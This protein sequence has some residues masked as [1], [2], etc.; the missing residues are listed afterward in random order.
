MTT[1]MGRTDVAER[2]RH[3]PSRRGEE[4]RGRRRIRAL[5][6]LLGLAAIVAAGLGFVWMLPARASLVE[7][8]QALLA[9]RDRLADGDAGAARRE[10]A[11]AEAAFDEAG[12]RLDGPLVRLAAL[13]PI[14]GR[15]PDAVI[16]IAD[17]GELVARAAEGV[18]GA[19]EQLPG[20]VAALAPRNGTI[21]LEPFRLLGPRF[22]QARSLLEEASAVVRETPDALLLGPVKEAFDTFTAELVEARRA[23]VA[24]DELSAALPSFLG[25]DGPRRYFLG[26]QHSAELRGTGGVL[27][28]YAILTVEDGRIRLGAFDEVGRIPTEGT[29]EIPPPSPEYAGLY[30]DTWTD[31]ALVNST[32]DF[33]TAATAMERL[34]ETGTGTRLDGIILADPA[35]FSQMLAV[36]GPTKVPGTGVTVDAGSVVPFITN[37]VYASLKSPEQRSRVFADMAEQVFRRYLFA[38]APADPAAAARAIVDAS[39]DGHL[40]FH[41]ADPAVQGSFVAS[42]VSGELVDRPGDYLAVV[43]NNATGNKIDF[44]AERNLRYGV[45]LL[46]DG[47]ARGRADL[48]LTNDAPGR[49][50]PQYVIGPYPGT[51]LDAGDNAMYVETYCAPG[52]ELQGFRTEGTPEEVVVARERGHPVAV[53]YVRLPAGASQDL[54]YDWS[55]SEAWQDDNGGGTYRLTVQGQPTI[56]PTRLELEIRAPAGMSITTVTPGMQ[57]DGDRAVWAGEVEDVLTFE[58]EFRP[59]VLESLWRSLLGIRPLGP[60]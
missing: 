17:A 10:F 2:G 48:T 60:D 15:T 56:R 23:V 41:S 16:A 14:L 37:E 8:R 55:V 21:P 46:P 39:A 51:G 3:R 12:S 43:A 32:P 28:A 31:W 5:L 36:T 11:R 34:Y 18:A 59:P 42:G 50:Q 45:T 40:L 13:V 26:A 53:K 4:R 22:D 29:S 1:A 9:G 38:E 6:I 24:A 49:G 25:G 19:T 30:P 33:P 20:G 35:A 58:V 47:T 52:C 44:Y 54:R 27:G 7:A 57:V